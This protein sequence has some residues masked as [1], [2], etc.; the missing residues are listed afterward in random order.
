MKILN[1]V[2]MVQN[3][4]CFFV[5]IWRQQNASVKLKQHI[6]KCL[7]ANTWDEMSAKPL[8]WFVLVCSGLFYNELSHFT[9]TPQT[10]TSRK[11]TDWSSVHAWK[12][13]F[14][15]LCTATLCY[16]SL[17]S[18]TSSEPSRQLSCPS[19]RRLADTQPPL[20]HTYSLT[21]QDGTTTEEKSVLQGDAL[22]ND[23]QRGRL[24]LSNTNVSATIRV[25]HRWI[26]ETVVGWRQQWPHTETHSEL[27]TVEKKMFLWPTKE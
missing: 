5:L 13:A 18:L 15:S 25:C 27:F 24:S 6:F 7:R 1:V 12:A 11:S 22:R 16:Y 19:Q 17:S 21:E 4:F 26:C 9:Q 14:W 2:A 10:I 3:V 23:S 20:V 8:F